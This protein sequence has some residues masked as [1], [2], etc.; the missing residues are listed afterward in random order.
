[1]RAPQAKGCI[2]VLNNGAG[3]PVE[4]HK[5]EG[6]Y[7]PELIFG[8]LLTSSNY[9]DTEKK[10]GGVPDDVHVSFPCALSG[11]GAVLALAA[12]RSG[13]WVA[14]AGMVSGFAGLMLVGAL[15][16]VPAWQ[17]SMM[18]P[19]TMLGVHLPPSLPLPI[20]PPASL[21]CACR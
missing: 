17:L 13:G 2:K 6:I 14:M 21:L 1:L 3:I 18:A 5:T 8:N 15:G 16:E 11:V 7:V 4:V 9:N 10:V 19:I 12:Q 20:H